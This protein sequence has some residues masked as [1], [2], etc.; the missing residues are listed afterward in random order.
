MD[1]LL[2]CTQISILKS[3][4]LIKICVFKAIIFA[5]KVQTEIY[6]KMK[7]FDGRIRHTKL[8]ATK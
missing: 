8:H 4:S 7:V 3:F 6:L 1:V 5:S 2:K